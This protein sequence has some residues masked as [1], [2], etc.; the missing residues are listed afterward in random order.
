MSGSECQS[1]CLS[2]SARPRPRT[3]A[4]RRKRNL[5][6]SSRPSAGQHEG[7]LC[8]RTALGR[9]DAQPPSSASLQSWSVA[10]YSENN[11]CADRRRLTGSVS[12]CSI[13]TIN[14]IRF[15]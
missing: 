11:L 12:N 2:N 15:Y 13:G 1:A 10:V 5:M 4:R 3:R 8:T 7:D 6:P 14:N 9:S